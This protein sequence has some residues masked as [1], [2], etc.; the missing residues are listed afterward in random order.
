M[1]GGFSAKTQATQKGGS[2]NKG[3][4]CG[5]PQQDYGILGSV[6]LKGGR[7]RLLAYAHELL[8]SRFEFQ[9]WSFVQKVFVLFSMK[10]LRNYIRY[11][12]CVSRALPS[13]RA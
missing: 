9:T 1:R 4:L 13:F 11:G 3:F 7:A 12:S 2:S 10:K 8:R 5:G 6:F